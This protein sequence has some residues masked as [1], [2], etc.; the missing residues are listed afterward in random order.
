MSL[1]RRGDTRMFGL[2]AVDFVD[3]HGFRT[4]DCC[5]GL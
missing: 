4:R 5:R 2:A 1:V 3:Q